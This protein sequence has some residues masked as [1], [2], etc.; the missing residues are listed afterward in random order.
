MPSGKYST[1]EQGLAH[2]AVDLCHKQHQTFVI[3]SNCLQNKLTQYK[4]N[5]WAIFNGV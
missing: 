5:N 2:L 4:F 1:L 3:K